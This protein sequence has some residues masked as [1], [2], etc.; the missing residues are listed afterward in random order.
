MRNALAL[1]FFATSLLSQTPVEVCTAESRVDSLILVSR[2][3]TANNDFSEALQTSAAAEKIALE[4]CGHESGAYGSACFNHG[5]IL[6]FQGVYDE[7]EPWYLASKNIREKVLGTENQDYGRSVNNLAILYDK[8]GQYEKAEQLYLEVLALRGKSP[9]KE[10]PAYA[11]ALSNLASLYMQMGYFE[12]SERL[13]LET[14]TIREK[15]LGKDDPVYASSLNNLANLYY[16]LHNYDKAEQLYSGAIAIHEKT[17][18]RENEDYILALDNLGAMYQVSGR[19]DRAEPLLMA[20]KNLWEK[21]VGKE[22]PGFMLSLNHLA[23][24]YQ[25]MRRYPEAE[26]LFLQAQFL[27]EKVLGPQHPDNV[28]NKQSLAVLYFEMG[29]YDKAE[30][31]LMECDTQFVRLLGKS[32]PYYT[33]NQDFL[34]NVSWASGD[35]KSAR[36]Y[37]SEAAT[38]KRKLLINASRHLSEHELMD[39]IR[40]F[41]D[42]LGKDCSFSSIQPGLTA[43]CYN[44]VL[45][46]K[47]F[48]LNAVSQVRKLAT[49]NPATAEK[50]NLFK[51]YHR[52]LAAEYAKPFAERKGV[53]TLEIESNKLE[54][55]L[56][57]SVAGYGEAVRQYSWQDVQSKLRPGE[58]AIEFVH[59]QFGNPKPTDTIRYAAL[60]LRPGAGEPQFIPLFEETQ[61]AALVQTPG[62]RKSDYVDRIYAATDRGAKPEE[63]LYQLL[64]QPLEK[65]LKAASPGGKAIKTVYFSPSGLLHCVNLAAVVFPDGQVLA[66]HYNLIQL[67]STRQLAMNAASDGVVPGRPVTTTA[68]ALL[69]GGILYEPDSTAQADIALRGGSWN[70]LKG[71]EKEV[72]QIGGMMRASGLQPD[73]RKGYAAREEVFKMIGE[74]EDGQ[75][76]DGATSSRP[77]ATSPRI[78]H[79]A[80]H[81]FFYHRKAEAGSKEEPV[82]KISDNP[83]MRSGLVLAGGNYAWA[84]GKPY[85]PDMEDGILTAYEIAQMDL[86]HTELVV[87]SAC[88]TGLGDIQGDEGVYGLQRAFKIA[89]AKYLVMSLWRVPDAATQE[90]MTAFYQKWLIQQ[91]PIPDAFRAAQKE[92]QEKY[93]HPFFWAGFVLVE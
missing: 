41:A 77:V 39:Y 32:H 22:H 72:D 71:T 27:G 70:Y 65:A 44:D 8:M 3:R 23:N 1:L 52:R 7:A 92:M 31:L 86:S 38:S 26:S 4:Q 74:G 9:G 89:G 43:T 87:L 91:N 79:F 50:Y 82:F 78:L 47:G 35:I 36:Y 29:Q 69:F 64:W 45:F 66:N 57:H 68:S 81:G 24:L 54:K 28:L 16:V 83:M 14:M 10:S 21:T 25:G 17:G 55:E 56:A 40:E 5:R 80:T 67:G 15:V 62:A 51:S 48:L 90:L 49:A 93:Q 76:S 42:V 73:V 61:L 60:L 37:L 59:Y 12:K 53:Q 34:A 58:A 20:S 88:E 75:L 63:T 46:Y 85:R 18:D 13:N 30:A 11:D 19:L 33:A 84:A 6:Y 2:S